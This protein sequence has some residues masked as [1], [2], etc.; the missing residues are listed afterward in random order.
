MGCDIHLFVEVNNNG[1]WESVDEWTENDGYIH[2]S[3]EN[4]LYTDR[5]YSMFALLANVRNYQGIKPICQPKG[6][7]SDV[8]DEV[9][10][11]S[12]S[13]GEDG[14]SHTYFTLKELLEIDWNE[15]IK[16]AGYMDNKR[17]KK[18]SLSLKTLHPDYDLRYPYS[19]GIGPSLRCTY[20]W[21]KWEIP[22]KITAGNFYDEV[23]PKLTE[24]G[25]QENVRIVFF[26]DN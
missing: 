24:L 13:W 3:Y 1:K 2:V 5:N 18:F 17:W 16:E 11:Y 22:L 19:Q 9:K 4:R 23:I 6:L 25:T 20:T 14:H 26:F 12:E 21:R 10:A 15:T 8:S 7:P